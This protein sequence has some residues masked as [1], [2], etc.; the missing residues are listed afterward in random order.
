[1]IYD[2][3]KLLDIEDQILAPYAVKSRSSRGREYSEKEDLTRT[4]FQ[5]DRDRIIHSR[6]FRRLKMKTQVFV[7]DYGD[8]YRTRITHSLE[9]AQVS[10]DI[11]RSL[12]L[13]EDLAETIALAHDL[14]HTPFGHAG[15]HALDECL[16]PFELHFEHNQQSKRIV[17]ELE[18]VYPGFRGLN[19]TFEVRQGLMK[20]QSPWDQAKNNFHG[21]SLEAQVVNLADEIAYNNHDVDDG[22][23]SGLITEQQLQEIAIW[24]TAS[25]AVEGQYGSIPQSSIRH[26]RTVSKM[27][28]LMIQDLIAHSEELLAKHDIKTLD[29]VYRSEDKLI[30]FSP[31]Q[32]R[33][34]H[35]LKDFLAENM[36]FHPDVLR[37]SERGQGII[38]DLFKVYH[39]DHE[40]LPIEEREAILKGERPAI[41][42]KDYIAGMTDD[43][44]EQEWEK[45]V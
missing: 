6:A 18:F 31:L 26:A 14:G 44:A 25:E 13:N 21:A 22:L 23:R 24:Q 30:L 9:V 38:K 28:G 41:A 16:Q 37:L 39:N 29:Q 34:N 4:P 10:R 42:I 35:E 40:L 20:H 45:H 33:W 19:L 27:I 8:H 11:S 2:L 43:F 17:E 36:Y 12:G 1:M 32:Y 3:A 5:K 7:A 15:E